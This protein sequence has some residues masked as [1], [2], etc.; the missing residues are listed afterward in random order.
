M[1]YKCARESL[2]GFV[3][4]HGARCLIKFYDALEVFSWRAPA[5][6][7]PALLHRLE[8]SSSGNLS[9]MLINKLNLDVQVTNKQKCFAEH[10][11]YD[12]SSI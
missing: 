1:C 9:L 4:M 10:M 6:T 3:V 2:E 5:S 12:I 8:E 11:S 7:H